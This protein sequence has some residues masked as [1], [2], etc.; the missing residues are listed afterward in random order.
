[1]GRRQHSPTGRG[2]FTL[3]ELLVVIGL[4]TVLLSLLLPAVARARAAARSTSCLSNIRHVGTAWLMYVAENKGCLPYSGTWNMTKSPEVAWGG[5]W[6]GV[7]D[8]YGIRGDALL[9]PTASEPSRQTKGYGGAQL[10]WNG[11]LYTQGSVLRLNPATFRVG[12]YGYN[13]YL[14][15][16]G[17]DPVVTKLSRVRNLSNVPA[18]MDCAWIDARPMEQTEAAPVD[19]PP[20]LGGAGGSAG[21][22]E[23]WRFLIARHGR[24]IN[25]FFADGSARWV[26]LE[27]TYL[28]KWNGVWQGYRLGNLPSR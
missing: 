16:E 2:G 23:H 6:L 22:P 21:A 20:D 14:T 9:C 11:E 15:P 24:G 8:Q 28:M 27:E 5:Y 1:M 7:A 17:D 18:F 12:S 26:L 4:I 3:V 25:V 10:A 13:A 19:A